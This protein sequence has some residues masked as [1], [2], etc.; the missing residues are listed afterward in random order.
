MP[1][2]RALVQD[3]R[4][5]NKTTQDIARMHEADTEVQKQIEANALRA[6]KENKHVFI[7]KELK[8]ARK[9]LETKISKLNA[10]DYDARAKM[11]RLGVNARLTPEDLVQRQELSRPE[12]AEIEAYQNRLRQVA[13]INLTPEILR[14]P[15]LAPIPRT[16]DEWAHIENG[17]LDLTN[18]QDR[19]KDKIEDRRI[20][21]GQYQ[22]HLK[23]IDNAKRQM[24]TMDKE[25]HEQKAIRG[26][27][28]AQVNRLRN[29]E[30]ERTTLER[31]RLPFLVQNFRAFEQQLVDDNNAIDVIKTRIE[32]IESQRKVYLNIVKEENKKKVDQYTD[33][34]KQLQ[35]IGINLTHFPNESNQDYYNRISMQADALSQDEEL[36][37][38]DLFI[39]RQFITH[40]RTLNLP[41]ATV[42][43]VGRAV[44]TP[45]KEY[46]LMIWTKFKS[47]FKE[48]FGDNLYRLA[49]ENNYDEIEGKGEVFQSSCHCKINFENSSYLS[50][51]F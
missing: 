14:K 33:K 48:H 10:I 49:N 6:S 7:S 17:R 40:L 31:R 22:G 51:S 13:K 3:T 8:E 16:N 43:N 32:Y 25:I 35:N 24:A 34:M 50:F 20:T 28:I 38:G 47:T 4:K 18:L 39:V 21:A 36:Q 1:K 2:P 41:L 44:S 30:V 29:L 42:E 23:L 37:D 27:T 12:Q 15:A 19:L 46:I 26:K 45:A 11:E 9:P 5:I